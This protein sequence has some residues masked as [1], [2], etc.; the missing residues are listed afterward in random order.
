MQI[1]GA[2]VSFVFPDHVL[3]NNSFLL[4]SKNNFTSRI[5]KFVAIFSKSRKAIVT[6]VFGLEKIRKERNIDHR[7]GGKKKKYMM[8][9]R[10]DCM[11]LSPSLPPGDALLVV[12]VGA[13]LMIGKGFVIF[14]N[15]EFNSGRILSLNTPCAC[16][17]RKFARV[18]EV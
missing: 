3:F 15:S 7:F 18:L 14:A 2:S 11:R 4:I 5:V 12:T 17:E 8:F 9:A 10:V 6:S 1:F 13:A 16:F